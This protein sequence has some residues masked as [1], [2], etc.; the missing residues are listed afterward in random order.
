M[1]V[2]VATKKPK[3]RTP[4]NQGPTKTPSHP[5]TVQASRRYTPAAQESFR[6]RPVWHKVLAAVLLLSGVG[7][8]VA[9]EASIGKIHAYGGHVWF[10]VGL[11]IAASSTWWFG[12]FDQV[13]KGF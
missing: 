8:F 6:F 13:P 10:L 2:C 1:R 9:C 7:V 12:L 5:D 3:R 11:V 4:P